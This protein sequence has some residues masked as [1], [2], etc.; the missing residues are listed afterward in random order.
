MGNVKYYTGEVWFLLKQQKTGNAVML[1]S[2]TLLMALLTLTIAWA[3]VVNDAASAVRAES[4]IDV[5]LTDDTYDV[6]SDRIER[7]FQGTETRVVSAEEAYRNMDSI[8]GE[9]QNVLSLFDENPLESYIEVKLPIEMAGETAAKIEKIT[10]VDYVRDNKAVL[11]AVDSF[12]KLSIRLSLFLLAGVGMGTF[13][14]LSGLIRQSIHQYRDHIDTMQLLGAPNA[15]IQIPFFGEGIFL[16][17][18]SMLIAFSASAWGI[19]ALL[20]KMRT[21]VMWFPIPQGHAV[22]LKTAVFMAGFSLLIGITGSIFGFRS[23][24]KKA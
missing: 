23:A 9:G 20:N 19:T 5:Y 4:E 21:A 10:G 1:M 6:V 14:I 3:L 8:L 15:F 7:M 16:S 2:M 24:I 12:T 18:L 17:F 11:D 13:L 22:M